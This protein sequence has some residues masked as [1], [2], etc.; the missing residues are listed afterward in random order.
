MKITD[1]T[2]TLFDQQMQR[3]LGDVQF[4]CVRLSQIGEYSLRPM[5]VSYIDGTGKQPF[6][7][8]LELKRVWDYARG[9]GPRPDEIREIIQDLCELLW[10][11]TGGSSYDIPAEFWDQPLGFMCR[12]A[13]A[14]E[15][16]DAGGELNAEQLSMLAGISAARV[17]Q[18]CRSGD[19]TATKAEQARN[20]QQEWAIPA[21]VARAWLESRK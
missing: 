5:P 7:L 8:A 20:R 13:W 12:L 6:P 21:D 15:T 1:M 3:L 10:S 18:L 9:S 14:R 17:K 2:D 4:W 16:L 19:I 11:H